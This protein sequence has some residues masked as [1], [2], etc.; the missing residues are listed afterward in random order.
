M[1]HVSGIAGI[2]PSQ[3]RIQAVKFRVNF[4]LDDDT[5]SGTGILYAIA[6]LI[7]LAPEIAFMERGKKLQ[8]Q[9]FWSHHRI[10]IKVERT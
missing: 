5:P 4:E 10:L 8:T 6:G 2:P 9:Q 1:G 7:K 3:D